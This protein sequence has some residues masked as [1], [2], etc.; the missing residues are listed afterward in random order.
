MH[1]DG[2]LALKLTLSFGVM[3][4]VSIF[5]RQLSKLYQ[6]LQLNLLML[7]LS[8]ILLMQDEPM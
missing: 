4:T 8:Q 7:H 5:N 2:W 3:Y 6:T 1:G